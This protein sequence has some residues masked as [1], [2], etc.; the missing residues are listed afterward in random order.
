MAVAIALLRGINVGGHHKIR[1][2]L[3]RDLCG[4][5]G[6]RDAETYIQSGNVVFRADARELSKLG[7]RLESA[8]EK[9]VGF[10]P[11]VIL[12]T[13]GDFRAVLANNPFA[14]REGIEPAKLAVTFLDAEPDAASRRALDKV[15]TDPEEIH[16]VGRELFVYFPEGMGRS[17]LPVGALE[18]AMKI[19]GTTR[20]WNTV[21]KLAAMAEA[22]D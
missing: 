4:T 21:T 16:L 18:K 19:A 10:R 1:M 15:E 11:A 22:L 12:R 8:I 7:G 2:D 17:K 13:L 5:A 14:G 6:M 9:A 3:L 20:N